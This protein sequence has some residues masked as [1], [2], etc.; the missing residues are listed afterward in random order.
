MDIFTFL[1]YN[2]VSRKIEISYLKQE[3]KDMRNLMQEL[4]D[5]EQK[6]LENR[7]YNFSELYEECLATGNQELIEKADYIHNLIDMK[8]EKMCNDIF[9]YHLWN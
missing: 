7:D 9:N 6:V 2:T 3:F 1:E 8:V 4:L 5:I